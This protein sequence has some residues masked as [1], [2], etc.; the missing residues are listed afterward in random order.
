MDL[1]DGYLHGLSERAR[2][3]W[4]LVTSLDFMES[5]EEIELES[6]EIYRWS[7]LTD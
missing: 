1:E 6:P 3:D 7:Y 4:R 2:R 5:K